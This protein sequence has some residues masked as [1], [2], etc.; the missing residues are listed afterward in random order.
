MA[1]PLAL[2]QLPYIERN[3][4][5]VQYSDKILLIS[6]GNWSAASAQSWQ[7]EKDSSEGKRIPIK[8]GPVQR[9]VCHFCEEKPP[10]RFIWLIR[11]LLRDF[12]IGSSLWKSSV[13]YQWKKEKPL[14][15]SRLRP[16]SFSHLDMT[17]QRITS[18]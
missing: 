8:W 17:H 4:S 7:M 12:P 16:F 9:G 14:T 11:R 1:F 6:R 18:E 5:S 3:F 15:E 13:H 2:L 10:E